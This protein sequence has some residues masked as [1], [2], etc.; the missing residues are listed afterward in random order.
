[1]GRSLDSRLRGNEKG[2]GNWDLRFGS[3]DFGFEISGLG[4]RISE[5]G[6]QGLVEGGVGGGGQVE[7]AGVG[8]G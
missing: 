1:M 6:G 8:E 3:S 5:C 7:G 4:F 2:Q